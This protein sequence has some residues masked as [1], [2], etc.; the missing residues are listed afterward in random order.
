MCICVFRLKLWG[1]VG[2]TCRKVGKG[3]GNLSV[4]PGKGERWGKRGPQSGRGNRVE[5]CVGREKGDKTK[6][7][8]HIEYGLTEVTPPL[9]VASVVTDFH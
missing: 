5:E 4:R 8:V 2:E 9:C 1:K 7:T 3:V 6:S